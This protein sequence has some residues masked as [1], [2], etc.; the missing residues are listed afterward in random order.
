MFKSPDGKTADSQI[1]TLAELFAGRRPVIP[2]VNPAM[3]KA[4]PVDVKSQSKLF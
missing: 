2:N 1:I 4:A 3:F